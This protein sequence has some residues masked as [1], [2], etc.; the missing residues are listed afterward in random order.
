MDR[1]GKQRKSILITVGTV[2]FS[3]ATLGMIVLTL[4]SDR[5]LIANRGRADRLAT[6]EAD[7]AQLESEN[8]ALLDE[9]RTLRF[10]PSEI[11]RR[12]REDLKLVK[13]GEVILVLPSEDGL[14]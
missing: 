3:V 12:A 13:P 4:V 1:H 7:I 2:I 10:D 9:I 6:L 5:G 14:Q 11:E 8:D